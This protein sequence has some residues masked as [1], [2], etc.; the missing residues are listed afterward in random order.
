MKP[1]HTTQRWIR[2]AAD[3]KAAAAGYYFDQKAAD[4]VVTFFS[5]FLRHSK[6]QWAGKAFALL[7]W[8]RDEVVAPMFGWKRPD[9][10]RRFREAFIAIPK[11][12]GKST[13]CGGLSLYF[14]TADNEPGA[15]VYGAG[16]DREQA[17]IVYREAAAMTKAAP[18]LAERLM[19]VESRKRIVSP[20]NGSFYQVLSA[21]AFRA[22]GINAH[23]TIFDEL[24]AQ[25]DRRLYD[26]LRY[27]GAARR[28]PFLIQITTAGSDRDSICGDRWDYAARVAAGTVEDLAFFPYLRAAS[29]TD[30]W[31]DPKTWAKANPSLGVT[32][33]L[34]DFARDVQAARISPG[35]EASFR[36][37]RLNQWLDA[38]DEA[39]ISTDRWDAG[40]TAFGA[41]ALDGRDVWL[42]LDL[43]RGGGDWT[44]VCFA[45]RTDAGNVRAIWRHYYPQAKFEERAREG[46]IPIDAWRRAG[47]ITVTPGNVTDFALVEADI[48]EFSKRAKI[49]SLNYDPAAAAELAQ[50]L[51][52]N[53]GIPL[54]QVPQTLVH[55]NGPTLDLE[56]LL[57]S[58]QLEHNGDPVAAWMAT[59]AVKIISRSNDLCKIAKPR[60][61]RDKNIDGLAALIFALKN[62]AAA[63]PASP[64]ILFA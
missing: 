11:K 9:G 36:R 44:S 4:H 54:M 48:A 26:A 42:G 1:N 28:Q 27:A 37:Y 41:D 15:E 47:W 13:L 57:E 40:Q 61:G 51:Q 18:S 52:D 64:G 34:E 53:H 60:L 23:A 19:L 29:S 38:A 62:I 24:H 31:L 55:L 5:K 63:A 6:G 10:R 45:T 43:A 25:P 8:Q 32:I 14:L 58:S 22:E 56:R 35:D 7:D 3:E 30:D 33:D 46:R 39:W 12:N 2:S 21:D 20:L 17:G 59:N 49:Q 50:R 16:S